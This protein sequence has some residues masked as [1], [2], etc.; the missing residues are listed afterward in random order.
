MLLRFL[1]SSNTSH[2]INVTDSGIITVFTDGLLEKA[3]NAIA[4]TGNP[5][6]LEGSFTV[7]SLSIYD[8]I[9]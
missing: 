3:L 1:Q 2:E 8:V 4:S 7:S 5:F 9:I 6:T